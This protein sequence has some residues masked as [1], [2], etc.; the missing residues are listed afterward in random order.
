[1][2]TFLLLVCL[3][4]VAVTA[5]IDREQRIADLYRQFQPSVG[6][7]IADQYGSIGTG[8]IT[9]TG[10][11]NVVILTNDHVCAAFKRVLGGAQFQNEMGQTYEF[12]VIKSD[13]S[14]DL[15]AAEVSPALRGLALDPVALDFHKYEMLY[16]LGYPGNERQTPSA[17]RFLFEQDEMVSGDSGPRILHEGSFTAPTFPGNS[18]SLI[19]NVWGEY[20]GIVNC[21][22]GNTHNGCFIPGRTIIEFLGDL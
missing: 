16:E 20:V 17:G 1:M 5:C 12:Q 2:R 19:F 22:D 14:V 21:T 6:H 18:G 13:P 9:R 11:G 7:F 3:S 8:V 15:C 4:L 10:K